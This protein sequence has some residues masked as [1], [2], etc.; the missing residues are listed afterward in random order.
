MGRS[1]QAVFLQPQVVQLVLS[2]PQSSEYSYFSTPS[3]RALQPLMPTCL[4]DYKKVAYEQ[5]SCSS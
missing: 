1:G 2:I 3:S 5:Q 4:G